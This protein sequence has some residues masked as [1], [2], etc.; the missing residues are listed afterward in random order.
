MVSSV[1]HPRDSKWFNITLCWRSPARNHSSTNYSRNSYQRSNLAARSRRTRKW[2]Q[3]AVSV[4]HRSRPSASL[5]R[6]RLALT[7]RIEC[8]KSNSM[9]STS[10]WANCSRRF[11]NQPDSSTLREPCY[12]KLMFRSKME[13]ARILEG[14]SY[15]LPLR[16]RSSSS[17]KS[18]NRTSSSWTVPNLS[19]TGAW[20]TRQAVSERTWCMS[21]RRPAPK[22][23]S[24]VRVVQAG[25][26]LCL[27]YARIVQL[28]TY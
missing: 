25:S 27:S 26:S 12:P 3:G 17:R 18:P 20:L 19:K 22:K 1:Y 21:L 7:R 2:W 9:L 23:T 11:L 28:K 14:K 6:S 8:S 24:T 13:S 4:Q 10:D 16:G 5:S 15:P